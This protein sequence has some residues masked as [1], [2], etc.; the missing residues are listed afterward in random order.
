MHREERLPQR[1]LAEVDP[2]LQNQGRRTRHPDA[3]RARNLQVLV[4]QRRPVRCGRA[5]SRPLTPRASDRRRVAGDGV[6]RSAPPLPCA[7]R[8]IRA[9]VP[10]APCEMQRPP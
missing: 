7:L 3:A 1:A 9:S 8:P 2:P 5:G 10:A 4:L 6:P